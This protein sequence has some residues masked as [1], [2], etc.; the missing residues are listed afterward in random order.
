MDE[1]RLL[2]IAK[3]LADPR[4]LAI[5]EAITRA[6]E[7]TCGQLAALFPVGQSTVSHHVGILER[8]D[9]VHVHRKGQHAI[10]SP[11][12]ETLAAYVEALKAKL[13]VSPPQR[14]D[15]GAEREGGQ[16]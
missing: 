10:F 1:R 11:R 8:A 2:R 6:G 13:F 5:L 16:P 14:P 3:A 7:I 9:L 12:P 15:E 4:R